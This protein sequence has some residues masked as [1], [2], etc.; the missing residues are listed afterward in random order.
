MKS[1]RIIQI[2]AKIAR[3]LCFI[4]FIVC[5]VGAAGASIGLIVLPLVKDMVI[6]SQNG[7]TLAEYLAS[8]GSPVEFLYINMVVGIF[9][10]GEGI[11]LCKINERFFKDELAIGTPFDHSVVSN[12]RRTG[13]INIIVSVAVSILCAI[14]VAIVQAINHLEVSSNYSLFSTVSF[15]LLLLLLSLFCDYGAELKDAQKPVDAI[16]E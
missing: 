15:G 10:C 5:I 8:Q 4:L 13:L 14:A 6:D 9:A 3:I 11:A 16:E 1:L 7:T 2:I 12:M